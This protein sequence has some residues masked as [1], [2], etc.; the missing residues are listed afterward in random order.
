MKVG[1]KVI[2]TKCCED[3]GGE[4]CRTYEFTKRVLLEIFPEQLGFS[5]LI[6]GIYGCI[7]V[8]NVIEINPLSKA[9]YLKTDL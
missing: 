1:D 2:V 5:F 3:S 6:K 9:L 4:C 8:R 7:L